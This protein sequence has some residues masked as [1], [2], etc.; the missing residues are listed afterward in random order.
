M[1]T[2]IK[3]QRQ[4]VGV[5]GSFHNQLMG[6]NSTLPVVGE[7]ATKLH[8]TDRSCYD[9]VEVSKDGNRVK[10]EDLQAKHDA[11]K[12]GG[13][14][15]QNWVFEKTGYFTQLVWRFNAWY[16]ESFVVEFDKNFY[17]EYEKLPRSKENWDTI[18]K[19][20]FDE[21]TNLKLVKGKTIRKKQYSKISILFGVRDY[22]YDWSF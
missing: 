19:P 11:T 18:I 14:G 1:E 5:A 20:L 12:E 6:N 9:V 4:K 2:Q 7:G 15:H 8:Y 10:L 13:M 22:Y 17:A 16:V 3:K 21:F